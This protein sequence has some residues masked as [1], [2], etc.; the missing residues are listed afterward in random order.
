MVVT[1]SCILPRPLIR[2]LLAA[3]SKAVVCRD[4]SA[5][6]PEPQEAAAFFRTLC[7]HLVSGR[8]LVAALELAGACACGCEHAFAL[9]Q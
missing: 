9:V 6:E 2:A 4:A 8:A 1:T 7:Q 5:P 3:G